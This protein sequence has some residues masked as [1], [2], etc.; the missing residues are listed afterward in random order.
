MR[1]IRKTIT[2]R[3][4]K[5]SKRKKKWIILLYCI[6]IEW[7]KCSLIQINSLAFK[8]YIWD[9]HFFIIFVFRIDDLC[10]NLFEG[11]NTV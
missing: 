3:K 2:D 5:Y 8:Y 6:N 11:V 7:E 10:I 9:S 4:K 1:L